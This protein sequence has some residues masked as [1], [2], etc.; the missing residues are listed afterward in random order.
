MGFY[1][2]GQIHPSLEI[3]NK[4]KVSVIFIVLTEEEGFGSI[5]FPA[6]P[7]LGHKQKAFLSSCCS[8]SFPTAELQGFLSAVTG[9]K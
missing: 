5:S 4:F 9:A 2:D 1:S 7:F 8:C 6:L 3:L